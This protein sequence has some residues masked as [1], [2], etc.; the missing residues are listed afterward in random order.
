MDGLKDSKV[1]ILDSD[2][3]SALLGAAIL[4]VAFSFLQYPSLRSFL[5]SISKISELAVWFSVFG[6]MIVFFIMPLLA[7]RGAGS[8]KKVFKVFILQILFSV[9]MGI[10]ME[11]LM[12][13]AY[14]S[15]VAPVIISAISVIIYMLIPTPKNNILSVSSIMALAVVGTSIFVVI[16]AVGEFFPPPIAFLIASVSLLVM[17]VLSYQYSRSMAVVIKVLVLQVCFLFVPLTML[18]VNY[19]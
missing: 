8:I 19:F 7:Y 18:V 9:I 15:L 14:S 12:L 6:L 16:Y 5:D 1:R 10:V 17:P 13:R 2:I 4:N 3:A 11:S